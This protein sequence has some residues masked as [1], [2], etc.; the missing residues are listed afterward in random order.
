MSN[1][2]K[3]KICR[4][5]IDNYVKNHGSKTPIENATH[6]CVTFR[7][8]DGDI[9][10]VESSAVVLADQ[11][12]ELRYMLGQTRPAHVTPEMSSLADLAYIQKKDGSVE[13]WTR[14]AKL[15]ADIVA[16]TN[17][18]GYILLS[19]GVYGPLVQTSSVIQPVFHED[20]EPEK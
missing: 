15:M 7:T 2:K 5:S 18:M 12:A 16:L 17:S 13:L 3:S 20:S 9:Y 10:Y 1:F 14:D 4:E 19:K 8:A 6:P 11:T